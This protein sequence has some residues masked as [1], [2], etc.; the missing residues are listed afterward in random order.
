LRPPA[1]RMPDPVDHLKRLADDTLRTFEAVADAAGEQLR[2]SERATTDV[3]VTSADNRMGQAVDHASLGRGNLSELQD[4]VTADLRKLVREPALVRVVAREGTADP[5][6]YYISRVTPV[7]PRDS[8][9][10]FTS[11][12]APLGRMAA[13]KVGTKVVVDVRGTRRTFEILEKAVVTPVKTTEWDGIDNTFELEDGTHPSIPSLRGLLYWQPDEVE[14]GDVLAELLGETTVPRNLLD[15]ARRRVVD[16]MELRDRPALDRFQDEIFRKPLDEQLMISGPPGSG[17]TTTLIKRLGQKLDLQAL[18]EEELALVERYDQRDG[19]PFRESWVMFTPTELLKQYLKE[20]FNKE[21]IAAPES[22]IRTWSQHRRELARD[23]L[24]I[25]RTVDRGVFSLDDSRFFL[26]AKALSDSPG[27]FDDFSRF[28]SESVATAL[29]AAAR[30]LA[31]TTSDRAK[32]VGEKALRVVPATV[33]GDAGPP[34]AVSAAAVVAL[35]NQRGEAEDLI[36]EE[37]ALADEALNNWLRAVLK[38]N[39]AALDEFANALDGE[40]ASVGHDDD[41][42]DD[43]DD[44]ERGHEAG[45]ETQ[46]SP[47]DRRRRA[48]KVAKAGL[49]S[50]A[51]AKRNGKPIRPTT[52]AGKVLAW[53]GDSIPSDAELRSLGERLAVVRELRVLS[54]PIRLYLDRVPQAYGQFRRRTLSEDAWYLSDA[55]EAVRRQ[56]LNGLEVDLI[57]LL[58]LTRARELEE[59][60]A[61][62]RAAEIE[63]GPHFEAI[64]SLRSARRAQV[65]V[66]EATDFSPIQLRCMLALA[67][68]TTRAFYASGDV[69]QRVTPWGIR[70]IEQMRWVAESLE[71]YEVAIG[72]RQ[73]RQLTEFADR[74]ASL[75]GSPRGPVAL[76]ENVDSTGL[77]PVLG[78]DLDASGLVEWIA[79][80]VL[81]IQRKVGRF[82]SIAVFVHQ[83]SEVEPLASA[84]GERLRDDNAAVVACP[85]G[86]V[87]GADGDVRVFDVQHI[88]G[89]EFEAALFARLDSLAEVGPDLFDKLLYVG[90]TRAATFLGLSC[91]GRLPSKL[92]P[93]RDLF[94]DRWT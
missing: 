2:A 46:E 39:S 58:M 13:R 11:Y 51:R 10:K 50:I 41:D 28:H 6:V 20:A 45:P 36:R 57:L 91:V 38:K 12:R 75:S 37:H 17:K 31:R 5:V 83:E 70:D 16:R 42:N 15:V 29:L 61:G 8:P 77:Q 86:R 25:L 78:E 76:P 92:A 90:A 67:H 32:A 24:P 19:R 88:K 82:P 21:G 1:H 68:P 93:L 26:T 74:L 47:K 44:E 34:P 43:E 23:V 14:E 55:G 59:R 64:R 62:A 35:H 18:D 4:Q 49:R 73:T 84:L 94:I 66:D 7:A 80:R 89:L 85:Q 22:R 69:L 30:L 9:H 79:R 65:L 3:F 48:G 53:M 40:P 72:Y 56:A 33:G 87:V 71:V 81:E 60:L 63:S 54:R 52:Q 27:W